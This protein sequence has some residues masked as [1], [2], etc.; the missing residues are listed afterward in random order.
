MIEN[1]SDCKT[2]LQEALNDNDMKATDLAE[3]LNISR[4]TVSQWLSGKTK[5][6]RDRLVDIANI[7]SVNPSWLM[8]LDVPKKVD[9]DLIQE[10]PMLRAGYKLSTRSDSS[11]ELFNELYFEAYKR[12]FFTAEGITI[13][14]AYYNAPPA[15]KEAVLKLLDLQSEQIQNFTS[16]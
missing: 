1:V 16:A 7:L 12:K 3:R 14:E 15:I 5:P 10:S 4:S 9:T 8:G 13:L 11:A 6:K 2:R